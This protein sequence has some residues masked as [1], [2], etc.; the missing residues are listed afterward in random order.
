MGR[1]TYRT[2]ILIL[3]LF[4]AIVHL[5][6][7]NLLLIRSGLGFSVPFTL[8]GLGYL[9]FLWV[10]F[11]RPAFL[12]GRRTLL[13]YAFMA[14]AAVTILAWVAIGSRDFVGYITKLDEV[15]L[16]VALFLNLRAGSRG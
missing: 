1:Q 9:T 7:L 5:V 12:I 14:F 6:V 3:G 10:F 13:H 8:N 2:A 16:I 15:L 11:R 4:T